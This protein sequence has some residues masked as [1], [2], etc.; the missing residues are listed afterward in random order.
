MYR[1]PF[2]PSNH[3]CRNRTYTHTHI[4][5]TA[6]AGSQCEWQPL[7]GAIGTFPPFPPSLTSDAWCV[8]VRGALCA[9]CVALA[10]SPTTGGSAGC[11]SKFRMACHRDMSYGGWFGCTLGSRAIAQHHHR[12][13]ALLPTTIRRP[14]P[15]STAASVIDGRPERCRCQRRH[16]D[17]DHH[18]YQPAAP[19]PDH[20]SRSNN[21][22]HDGVARRDWTAYYLLVLHM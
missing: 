13:V 12:L 17:D 9:W 6:G 19:Q 1:P 7:E 14:W 11:R 3:V 20:D 18:H 4:H 10:R 22:D 21:N 5:T 15:L 16:R 8:W 2:R